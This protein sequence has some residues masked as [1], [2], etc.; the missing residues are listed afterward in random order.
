MRDLAQ[1]CATIRDLAQ[2][3]AAIRD[4]A[5][6]YASTRDTKKPLTGTENPYPTLPLTRL[7]D[8]TKSVRTEEKRL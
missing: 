8:N 4:S 5:R 2:S 1:P 6:S 3:C 7:S